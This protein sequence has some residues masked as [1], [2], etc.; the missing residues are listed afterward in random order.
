MSHHTITHTQNSSTS[1]LSHADCD[2]GT[3]TPGVA[4]RGQGSGVPPASN[5]GAPLHPS[6]SIDWLEFTIPVRTPDGRTK[7]FHTISNHFGGSSKLD[8][9]MHGYDEVFSILGS[10]FI[11][12]H[13]ERLDMGIHVSIPAKALSVYAE[14]YQKDTLSSLLIH[15]RK[16]WK[17]TA[18]RI[19]IAHDTPCIHIDTVIEAVENGELVTPAKKVT[20]MKS[21]RGEPGATVYIGSPN[22]DRRVRIYDKA[23]EQGLDGEVWT[24]FETQYRKKYAD[25][26]VDYILNTN[27]SMESLACTS[28]DF[29]EVGNTR[30]NNRPRS[31]W[32]ASLLADLE[33]I[34]FVINKALKTVEEVAE[35]FDSMMGATFAFVY[36]GMGTEWFVDRFHSWVHRI[37]GHKKVLLYG[38]GGEEYAAT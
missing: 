16:D 5:T 23:A 27:V 34:V 32:F 33:N 37:P 12:W 3:S 13:S 36:E 7:L 22:S 35:W 6:S 21:M 8:R 1:A 30:T 25:Q 31:L 29:R 18:T 28:Y 24:R 14:M 11:M 26:V 38:A 20:L 9:G 10:G 2:V 19:D 15:M 4:R 17:G